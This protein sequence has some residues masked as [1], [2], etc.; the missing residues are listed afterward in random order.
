MC[1]ACYIYV[2]LA[3]LQ[4]KDHFKSIPLHR[5]YRLLFFLHIHGGGA[6]PNIIPIH[7]NR[8]P[9]TYKY[10][11]THTYIGKHNQVC[12]FY[13]V[14]VEIKGYFSKWCDQE[15]GSYT[16]FLKL[17]RLYFRAIHTLPKL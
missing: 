10:K 14:L 4:F 8:T 7:K 5:I 2:R 3:L 6:W 12:W 11:H 17:Y 1:D 16:F 15:C 9:P 13:G